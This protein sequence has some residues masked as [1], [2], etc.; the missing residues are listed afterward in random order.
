M[1]EPQVLT[2]DDIQNSPR[3]RE[4]GVLPGDEILDN[5]IQRKFS[6]DEDSID[7]GTKI[8][9]Q[10]IASSPRLQELE[11]KPGDRI[12]D[13]K[14]IDTETDDTFTQFM[15]GYDKQNNF[16]GFLTDVLEARIPLGRYGFDNGIKYYSPEELYGEGFTEAG[17]DERREMIL[18]KRERDLMMEYGPYF[19]PQEGTAQAIGEIAGTIA[20]PSTLIPIGKTIK[21]ATAIASGIGGSYSAVEDLAQKGE[22]DPA[23]LALYTGIGG[24][25]GGTLTAAG[26]AVSAG[27]EKRTLK[28]ANNLLDDAESIINTHVDAGGTISKITEDLFQNPEFGE[29]QIKAAM[30]LTGRKLKPRMMS[31]KTEQILDDSIANDSAFARTVSKTLDKYLGTLS[32][33]IGN[34][35]QPVLRRMRKFEFDVH[36]NTA[37]SLET[38]NPFIKQMAALRNPVTKAPN[39]LHKEIT[40]N[41]YNGNFYEAK[42]LM[43][44]QEMKDSFDIVTKELDNLYDGLVESGFSFQKL[45]EYFPRRLKDYDGLL[46]DLGKDKKTALIRMQDD[47]AKRLGKDSAR[48]LSLEEKTEVANRYARGYRLTI[49]SKPT[50]TKQRTMPE[51]TTEQI[52]KYYVS[53]E[54]SLSLYLRNAVNSRER[55]NFF[56][57]NFTKNEKGSFDADT[58]I[59]KIIEEEKAAGRLDVTKEDELLDL[60]KSRFM[61]GE[62]S[63][64]SSMGVIRDLG[65]MGTIANPISAITQFGD[66]GI[67]GGLNG[68]R[69][70]LAAMFNKKDIKIIDIGLTNIQQEMAEGDVR[71]SAK[72]LNK[73]FT[74]SGFRAVDRLGKESLMNAAFRKNIKLLKSKR[75]EA[76]FRKKWSKFY[77]NEIDSIINDHKNYVPKNG[78]TDNIKFHAFNELSDTQPITMLEMP[79]AYL[80]APNGRILYM[81]KSFMLKQYDVLRR[82][83][84]QEYKKGNKISAVKKGAA[85]AGYL[86]A[87]NVGTQTIKDILLGR[88]I[89]PEQLPTQAMWALT[90]IYGLNK[91]STERYLGQGQVTEF[92][93]RT[94]VPATPVIDAAFKGGKEAIDAVYG[95]DV[96]FSPVLKGIPL[97]GPMTYN[98]FGGGAEKYNKRL[99][100]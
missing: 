61:G 9:E 26:K 29:Q 72:I 96:D 58:S 28:L 37:K 10:D 62:Q 43:P 84:V 20:D 81:L 86:A 69:N 47:Y 18:R 93:Y 82:N 89:R 40:K 36:T 2:L 48:D 16:V 1:A 92:A 45:E 12:V 22:I 75:G 90:G 60:V 59:G 83:V 44:T 80:D 65:Y 39:A 35:S 98:W 34:I 15:Y 42:Q 79:Q 56:G 30:A 87:A 99:D 100:D 24:V 50:F 31:S 25:A 27:I 8:S 88:E 46:N 53:P 4:L 32:T 74:L 38:V 6:S 78:I 67:S 33:R 51:L 71:T 21:A 63:V 95:E 11:A 68:F 41:L 54:E 3:L 17:V 76:E 14:I 91:Y 55:Y 7:L 66:L 49:D 23:K 70:T 64:G 19:E 73:L 94:V 97:V 13:N 85:L 57:R 52:E 77:G 5:K